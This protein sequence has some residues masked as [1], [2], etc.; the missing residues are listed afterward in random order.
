MTKNAA[1]GERYVQKGFG[2][3]KQIKGLLQNDY[4][5][6]MVDALREA[7]HAVS[8]GDVTVR[9]AKDFGFCYGVDRA[10]DLAYETREHFP[11]KTIYITNEIIHNPYVNRRLVELGVRFLGRDYTSADVTSD[12]VVILPAFGVTTTEMEDLRAK[13]CVLVDTTCGSVMNVWRRVRQYVKDGRTS[14]IH[15]KFAHEETCATSS[16]AT[17]NGCHYIV[18]RDHPEAELACAYIRQDE[19]SLSREAFQE[20]FKEAV[21]PG[22]DPDQHLS[23]IGLANQTTMLSTESLEIAEML[24]EAVKARYGEEAGERFRSF[25]TICSATQDLQDAALE[26]GRQGDLDL[27]LVVGGYNSSNTSHLVEIGAKFCPS[28]HI[29][30][31]TEILSESEIQHQAL[32]DEH[33]TLSRDWLPAGPI[34]IGITAGASTPNRTVGEVVERVLEVRKI[35][36][37][38][39]LEIARR[40]AALPMAQ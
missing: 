28:F 25:D 38:D 4:H 18:V 8:F 13:G 37:R 36:P 27:L 24:G 14:V 7:G 16:R 12:D 26:L 21:S 29:D 15:G 34:V 32:D 35:D 10:V 39:Y 40:P 1:K 3:K 17:E 33:T 11:D 31:A 5:S 6:G 19:G 23:H 9:L 22:F 2:L 30:S 20:R